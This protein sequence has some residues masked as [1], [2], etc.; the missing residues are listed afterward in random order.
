MVYKIYWKIPIV[1]CYVICKEEIEILKTD[2]DPKKEFWLQNDLYHL[3]L[4]ES[5]ILLSEKAWLNDIIMDA[6]QT[7]ICRALGKKESICIKLV[8]EEQVAFHSSLQR[9]HPAPARR[10]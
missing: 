2:R 7:L 5:S 4:E 3:K 1:H 10:K 8:E 6:A 9:A